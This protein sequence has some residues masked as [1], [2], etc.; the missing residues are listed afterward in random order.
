M[1]IKSINRSEELFYS[2][3]MEINKYYL[4]IEEK[5]RKKNQIV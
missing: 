5:L 2:T 1:N 4:V 3:K